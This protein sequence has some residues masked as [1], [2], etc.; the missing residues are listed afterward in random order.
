MT[1]SKSMIDLGSSHL[2]KSTSQY[3][4]VLV[5]YEQLQYEY[6]LKA[7]QNKELGGQIKD[8]QRVVK[9]LKYENDR[10][11]QEVAVLKLKKRDETGERMDTAQSKETEDNTYFKKLNMYKRQI[12]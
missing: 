9:Q 7:E 4:Q 2:R 5:N 3:R 12:K 6:S 8:S 1:M 11:Q 10:L